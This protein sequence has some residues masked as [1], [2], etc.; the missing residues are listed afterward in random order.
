MYLFKINSKNSF[1]LI[2]KKKS[3]ISSSTNFNRKMALIY[4][5]N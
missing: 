4:I 1:L 3:K 2:L 5:I